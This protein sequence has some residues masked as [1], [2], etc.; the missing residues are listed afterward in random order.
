MYPFLFL[1]LP[2]FTYARPQETHIAVESIKRPPGGWVDTWFKWAVIMHF[3][4]S[5]KCTL[6]LTFSK[7]DFKSSIEELFYQYKCSRYLLIKFAIVESIRRACLRL[8]NQLVA[9]TWSECEQNGAAM[10]LGGNELAQELEANCIMS[11]DERETQIRLSLIQAI[12][13]WTRG[14][15]GKLE[16]FMHFSMYSG[17]GNLSFGSSKEQQKSAQTGTA[18]HTLST[19][20]CLATF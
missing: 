5:S 19:S 8:G 6:L 9:R 14:D 20:Q 11:Q 12:Y 1:Q 10:P 3:P 13:Q 16:W 17:V 2:T 15:T 18:I 4:G 7:T